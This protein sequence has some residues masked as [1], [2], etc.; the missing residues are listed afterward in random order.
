VRERLHDVIVVR[1]ITKALAIPGLRAGYAVAPAPLAR[2]LRALRPPW[3]ANALALAA[4]AATARRPGALAAIAERAS[5]ERDDLARRLHAV[6]GLRTWPSAANFCLVEVHDGPA[7]VAALRERGIAVR[8][9]A[10]FPGL[11][12]R[13]I[14]LTARDPRRN[15]VLVAAI[16]EALATICVR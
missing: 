5:A 7:L 15:A 8:P 3:S 9:A 12:P 6:E 16:A 14:R 2:E 1:S 13:H 10:S 4:L 11:G